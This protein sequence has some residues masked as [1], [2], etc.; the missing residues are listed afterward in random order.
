[1][2]GNY[3][4]PIKKNLDAI[5]EGP[6]SA[7]VRDAQGTK[8]KVAFAKN[9]RLVWQAAFIS[10]AALKTL[11]MTDIKQYSVPD[12]RGSFSCIIQ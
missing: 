8:I 12:K 7:S 6:I 1:V 3:G 5:V 10:P 9:G 4:T 2:E 11:V